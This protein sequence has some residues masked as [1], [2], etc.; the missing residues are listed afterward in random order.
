MKRW[1]EKRSLKLTVKRRT[2][3][4]IEI[5]G[6]LVVF[7]VVYLVLLM[8]LLKDSVC[9]HIDGIFEEV[10]EEL[11]LKTRSIIKKNKHEEV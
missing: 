3:L 7:V 11:S 6:G 9:S 2:D 10:H 5:K 8:L 4:G 1:P